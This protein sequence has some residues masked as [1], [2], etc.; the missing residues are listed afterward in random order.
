MTATAKPAAG[1]AAREVS[2]AVCSPGTPARGGQ[3]HRLRSRRGAAGGAACPCR[4]PCPSPP[5]PGRGARRQVSRPRGGAR[6]GCPGSRPRAR[7]GARSGG[8]RR[9]ARGRGAVPARRPPPRGCPPP[10]CWGGREREA[11]RGR[12]RPWEATGRSGA[13]APRPAW[14]RRGRRAVGAR[15]P[16]VPVPPAAPVSSSPAGPAEPGVSLGAARRGKG[17]AAGRRRPLGRSERRESPVSPPHA[18]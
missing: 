11:R 12:E 3:R 7:A 6:N 4:C 1:D 15:P 5:R 10:S 9:R 2:S 8:G 14:G 17:A 18:V 13:A 16:V